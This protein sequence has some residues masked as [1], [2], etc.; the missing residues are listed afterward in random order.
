MKQRRGFSLIE[1]LIVI[2]VL[3]S[4]VGLATKLLSAGLTSYLTSGP[5]TTNA[6]RANIALSTI[7]REIQSASSITALSSGASLITYVNHAGDSVEIKLNGTTLSRNVASSADNTLCTNVTTATVGF[8]ADN[9]TRITL[10][11]QVANVRYILFNMVLE[12]G[13]THYSLT[14]GTLLRAFY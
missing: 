11:A 7:M 12:N 13:H 6:S 9:L 14:N 2:V 10:P 1:L 4:I 5:I 8:Y 3:S